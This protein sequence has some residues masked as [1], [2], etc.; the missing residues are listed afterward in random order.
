M[1]EVVNVIVAFAVIVFIVRWATNSTS[2]PSSSAS[3]L[4]LP[5]A[6][7]ATRPS[8]RPPPSLVSSQRLSPRRWYAFPVSHSTAQKPHRFVQLV[9][10]QSM[11]PDIPQSVTRAPPSPAPSAHAFLSVIIYS[12][13]CSERAVWRCP[14]ISSSSEASFQ[15]S[16]P[17]PR[18]SLSLSL[19]TDLPAAPTSLLLPLPP[20]RP[21][22]QPCSTSTSRRRV[23]LQSK[24]RVPHSAIPPRRTRRL[25]VWCIRQP[26]SRRRE[27]CLGGQCR[28]T[29]GQFEGEKGSDDL[30]SQTVRFY[31]LVFSALQLIIYVQTTARSTASESGC[32]PIFLLL[33]CRESCIIL[34]HV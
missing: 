32:R 26:R 6:K 11:F 8:P 12:T 2:F 5:K 33:T 23:L 30:G 4:T 13:I 10:V 25:R 14:P 1:G 29:R 28:E 19:A 22:R 20:R 15:P 7:T 16:V 21:T 27:E 3:L 18:Y 31:V 9:T 17:S 24:V 34:V